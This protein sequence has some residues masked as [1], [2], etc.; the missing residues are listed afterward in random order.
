[1][2]SNISGTLLLEGYQEE[3]VILA[4]TLPRDAIHSNK[5]GTGSNHLCNSSSVASAQP[6][7]LEMDADSRFF[8]SRPLFHH[9]FEFRLFKSPLLQTALAFCRDRGDFWRRQIK[10]THHIFPS[11]REVVAEAA[12]KKSTTQR[13]PTQEGQEK[14][15][16]T[17]NKSRRTT[18]KSSSFT[19]TPSS[20]K[21]SNL[22]RDLSA[23]QCNYITANSQQRTEVGTQEPT[24]P[25]RLLHSFALSPICR[26]KNESR[27]HQ[28]PYTDLSQSEVENKAKSHL[29]SGMQNRDLPSIIMPCVDELP[30]SHVVDAVGDIDKCEEENIYAEICECDTKENNRREVNYYYLKRN[31]ER[32]RDDYYYVQ[33]EGGSDGT[34]SGTLSSSNPSSPDDDTNYDTVC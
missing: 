23:T 20:S 18:K 25:E 29:Y 19:Y 3:D 7:L 22:T 6:K 5:S 15:S 11:N 9:E 16:K 24:D 33:L 2:F 21:G 26:H 1:L 27:L 31:S 32:V 17:K 34:F 4:C 10:V 28:R 14:M 30:Y 8:L 13:Q 12:G